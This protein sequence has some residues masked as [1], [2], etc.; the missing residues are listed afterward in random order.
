MNAAEPLLITPSTGSRELRDFLDAQLRWEQY[1]ASRMRGVHAMAAGGF[2]FWLLLAAG[3]Q[4]SEPMRV[5]FV[6][7]WGVCLVATGYAL[8]MERFWSRRRERQIE[9]RRRESV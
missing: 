2:C 8:V 4:V 3:A 7:S 5:L 9:R 6:I 1:H